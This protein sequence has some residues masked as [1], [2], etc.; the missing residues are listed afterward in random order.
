MAAHGIAPIIHVSDAN[1]TPIVGA[2]CYVYEVGTTT[3]RSIYSDAGLS[4][5]LSN[6]LSGVNASDARGNFPRFYQASG[7]YKIRL[8]TS[9]A[10][11]ID[12]WDNVDTGLASGSPLAVANGGTGATTASAARTNLDVPSNSEIAD[13][14]ADITDLSSAVQN[15][16]AFPQGYLTITSGTP[17]IGS[18]SVESATSI[19]Y[20]PLVGAQIPIYNG[21][22]YVIQTFTELTLALGTNNTAG[23]IY[24]CFV[25]NDAGTLRLVTG[26]AWSTST[27][28]SGARGSGA[29]T[30]ELERINGLWVNAEAMTGRYGSG[31]GT[32][33]SISQNQATYVGTIWIDAT[34]GQVTCHRTHAR[35]TNDGGRKW[36]I[37]NA[38][39]RKPI[40]LNA[41]DPST[42]WSYASATVRAAS[43]IPTSYTASNWNKGSTVSANGL[44]VISGL[45]EESVDISYTQRIDLATG[46]GTCQAVIG[47]GINSTTVMNGQV[48]LKTAVNVGGTGLSTND[49][50]P[51]SFTI[52]PFIGLNIV[53]PLEAVPTAG[54]AQTFYGTGTAFYQLMTARWMG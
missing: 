52:Y 36:G 11:L 50:V 7:T 39:N 51:A 13:I 38:Y 20:T 23:S 14:A 29:G 26:P 12:E 37:W 25:I 3:L 47:I 48:G 4:V 53:V 15:I 44:I 45:P 1:G 18:S 17:V 6:P 27:P 21:T 33:V 40:I 35:A 2:V 5:P 34:A 32:T 30:T 43:N 46:A 16:A 9:A 24:D 42:T 54:S 31:A 22:N 19:Y 28:G 10:A 8:E 41:S 49:T